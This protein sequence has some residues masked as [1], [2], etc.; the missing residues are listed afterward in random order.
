MRTGMA[1]ASLSQMARS[2]DEDG[3]AS[4]SSPKSSFADKTAEKKS[5]RKT[6]SRRSSKKKGEV[7]ELNEKW[8]KRF[9][10]L[11]ERFDKIFNFMT[12]TMSNNNVKDTVTLGE[13]I[14]RQNSNIQDS[15]SLGAH[16]LVEGSDH[17]EHFPADQAS[18]MEN[19]HN[20]EV[21]SMVPGRRELQDIGLLSDDDS[22]SVKGG[23]DNRTKPTS[24]FSKYVKES[25]C[26][27]SDENNN[28]HLKSLFGDDAKAK[29]ES[30]SVGIVLDK[31]QID[32]LSGSWRCKHPE[33]LTAYS[34][35]Y[36]HS[37][38]VH[39]KTM[40]HLEVPSLDPLVPDL[41]VKKHGSKAFSATRK[42]NLFTTCLKSVEKLAYQG[43][44]ASRMGIVT[45]AYTQQ[46]L[47]TLLEN[48]T[49]E[50][51][52]LDKSIQLVRD[53]F[54]MSTK[55]LDQVAR[56]GAFHHLV[57]RKLTMEDTGL[58]DIKEL[59]HPLVSLPLTSSGVLGEVLEQTLKD[60][61]DKNKQLKELLPELHPTP[62]I[63]S[64]KRKAVNNTNNNT[65]WSKKPKMDNTLSSGNS[66]Y[67]PKFQRFG[68][69]NSTATNKSDD[70]S[71]G[72][73]FR[74]FNPNSGKGQQKK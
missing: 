41:L 4:A 16:R 28:D 64:V 30:S 44:V 55:S 13:Q 61:V 53:I 24:R 37:F 33:K 50:N 36:K 54:A 62:K 42:N 8:E 19:D 6:S 39:D 31:S 63:F 21:L 48:L 45:T 60:R 25:Q 11:D 74:R 32:I 12:N 46:A 1:E 68:P 14:P 29:A 34:E 67:T 65:D 9:S 2:E 43:Q 40:E 18:D 38:P 35:E 7:E 73:N 15:G 51:V 47:A 5:S 27:V 72:G 52:N 23:S 70:K 22:V 26:D 59:K 58:N 20:S 66:N 3:R 69:K 49:Q 56:A 17:D 57:R 10:N 71:T